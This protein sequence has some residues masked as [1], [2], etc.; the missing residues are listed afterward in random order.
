ML[1]VLRAVLLLAVLGSGRPAA[2]REPITLSGHRGGV[3]CVSFSP[4][5]RVVASGS[6]DHTVKL[7]Q[8]STAIDGSEKQ[9]RRRLLLELDDDR[10]EAREKA[11]AE[12]AKLGRDFEPTLLRALKETTSLE[13]R[14]RLRRLLAALRVPVEEEHRDEVRCVAFSPDGKLLA[15]GSKDKSIKLWNAST[16]QATATFDGRSGTVWSVAFSPDGST[17]AS[18]G[19]DHSVKLWDVATRR[20]HATLQGHSGPVHCVAFSPD[21]KTLASAGSFDGTVRL[22]SVI[23]SQPKA[24]LRADDGAV[25]CVAISPDG[26]LLASAGY[27]GAI[28]LWNVAA[29][30]LAPPRSFNGHTNAVRSLAFSSDGKTLASAG[31]DHTAKLWDVGSG[32]LLSTLKDHAG[33]VNSVAFS[34]DGRILATAGLDGTVK[35]WNVSAWRRQGP[36]EQSH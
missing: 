10:F 20:L 33:G 14:A 16:N 23:D 31:E 13:V 12:L 18:G 24:A 1:H 30:K 17:L 25:L 8:L 32:R 26:T 7:W 34:A 36:V 11:S 6:A 4:D 27:E 2:A 19:M 35:L 21:G 3:L 28:K 15:S 5:G 29:G 9:R 22:W